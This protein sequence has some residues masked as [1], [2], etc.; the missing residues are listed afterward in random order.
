MF[1][2]WSDLQK[3]ISKVA[4]TKTKLKYHIKHEKIGDLCYQGS[5]KICGLS[6]NLNKITNK[7]HKEPYPQARKCLNKQIKVKSLTKGI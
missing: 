2:K 5:Q 7:L 6:K 4:A 3:N 1:I